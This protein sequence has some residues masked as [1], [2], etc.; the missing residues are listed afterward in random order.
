MVLNMPK[1]YSERGFAIYEEFSDTQQTIVKVQKSSLAEENCV[2]IL[3]NNHISSHP[4]KYFPPHLNV[5]QA[6]RVIKALQEFV[7]DNE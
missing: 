5:E 4:D 7:R 1:N 3:G 2:F 6:K